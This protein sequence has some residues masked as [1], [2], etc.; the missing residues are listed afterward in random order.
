M[1]PE[2]EAKDTIQAH[3][4]FENKTTLTD[5]PSGSYDVIS[6]RIRDS[7]GQVDTYDVSGDG[8]NKV[9]N[10]TSDSDVT[11]SI[12]KDDIGEYVIAVED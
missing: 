7:V 3:L 6:S 5:V 9:F 11:P 2:G 10:G 1:F 12:S 4:T 8:E